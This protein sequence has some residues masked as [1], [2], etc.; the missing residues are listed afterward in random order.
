MCSTLI[1]TWLSTQ[2]CNP[3]VVFQGSR[4]SFWICSCLSSAGKGC[5]NLRPRD[6]IRPGRHIHPGSWIDVEPTACLK[7]TSFPVAVSATK[8]FADG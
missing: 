8:V 1:C 5:S 6:C 2:L 4:V 3:T 7:A